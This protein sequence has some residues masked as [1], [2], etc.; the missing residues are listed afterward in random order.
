MS[1]VAHNAQHEFWRPPAAQ[2]GAAGPNMVEACD[3]CGTE[4]M[5]GARFCHVCGAVRQAQALPGRGWTRYLEFHI[6]KHG[7]GLSTA[8]LVAFLIG[9]ACALAALACGFIYSERNVLE[10]QAVQIYR[11]Q[12]LL[13]AVAAFVGG[14]LLRKPSGPEK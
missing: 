14:L 12:W 3:G 6:I 1:E 9:V 10:W 4:F 13:A 2:P 5:V 7:L 11:V 8:S